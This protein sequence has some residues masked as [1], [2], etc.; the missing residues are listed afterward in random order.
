MFKPD[1]V[2]YTENVISASAVYNDVSITLNYSLITNQYTGR[3]DV[4][5]FSYNVKNIGTSSHDV[6]VRIMFDT[7][8]GGNDAS[9]FRIP[10]VGDTSSETDLTGDDVPEFWQSF[11]SL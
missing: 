1:T 9:P 10:N 3:E 8:L 7:M 4:A 6:G 2:S 5:E 11:D